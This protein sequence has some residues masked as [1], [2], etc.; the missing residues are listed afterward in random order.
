MKIL[1]IT[2]LCK[3]LN[4]LSL[5]K[6]TLFQTFY[7]RLI[8]SVMKC[9]SGKNIYI[10]NGIDINEPH[11]IVIG[12]KVNLGRNTKLYAHSKILI[13]DRLSAATGLL[14]VA[15]THDNLDYSYKD[16]PIKIGDDVWIGA[17]VTIIGP[18]IVANGCI[19]AAGS[20]VKG[21]FPENSIIAGVPAK[22][23]GNRRNA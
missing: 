21:N 13:G 10:D 17:R 20:V 4:F 7:Q 19:V 9:K 11:N 2:F 18:T 22:I 3:V 12:E 16:A 6:G 23:I 8:L 14:V 15:G 1:V 5:F